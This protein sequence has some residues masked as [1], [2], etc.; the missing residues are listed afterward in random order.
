MQLFFSKYVTLFLSHARYV[1]IYRASFL[2]TG[3]ESVLIV[4]FKALPKCITASVEDVDDPI[5]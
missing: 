4:F 1:M 5:K 3:S 2:S